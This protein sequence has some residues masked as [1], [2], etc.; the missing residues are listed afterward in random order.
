[1][2]VS[3]SEWCLLI[4]LVTGGADSRTFQQLEDFAAEI[5]NLEF[6]SDFTGNSWTQEFMEYGCYCNKVV[7]GGGKL[8]GND[9]NDV[10]E[11]LCMVTVSEILTYF[12]YN[13][14]MKK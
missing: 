11:N 3:Q 5:W 13:F 14:S 1:M 9:K 4:Y 6:G 10:H 8:P 2:G 7:R 12:L